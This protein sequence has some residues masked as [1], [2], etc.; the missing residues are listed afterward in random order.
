[1]EQ[2]NGFKMIECG[3]TAY[4][5]GLQYGRE[6]KQNIQK[7][8]SLLIAG[9]RMSP[10]RADREKVLACG[11]KYL[12]NVK[13]F[14]SSGIDRVRGMADGAEISFDEAFAIHCY[15]ELA[16][17]YPYLAGMC[18]SFAA[19][20]P[21]T[22]DGIT[23]LGQN[24]DWHPDTPLDLLRIRHTDGLEQM[25]ITFFGTPCCILT[26]KGIG[27]C[28]NLTLA[29][30]G[31]VTNH[32]PFSFYLFKAMRQKSFEDAFEV[33]ENSARGLQYYHLA[34]ARGNLL[35]IES[36][37]DGYSV[38]EAKQGMLV[39]ANHYETE[40]YAKNDGA[41]TFITDSFL[42]AP[43]LRLLIEQHYG[44]LTPE[45]MM[46]LLAD[47]EG[48]PNSICRHV[49]G[50]K[51]QEFASMSKASFI[52]IPAERKMYI[53]AGPPCENKYEEYTL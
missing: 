5:I 10:F 12:A 17:N 35:G 32:I 21:A 33:L 37:Y 9:L 26:T 49:D 42:R 19:T 41:H 15:M 34:D 6:A 40:E 28:A 53:C 24:I 29:P 3:G 13:A 16:I 52:M 11:K 43:R 48:Y 36:I 7:A 8:L 20:G 31:P 1:M 14:D 38:L 18:T 25:A 39:H 27:N 51:P 47:H 45:I 30:M 50:S 2:Q 44:S 23:M 22:K 46:A 4:E